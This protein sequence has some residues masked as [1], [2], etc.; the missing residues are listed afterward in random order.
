MCHNQFSA[1]LSKKIFIIELFACL[2]FSLSIHK[3]TAMVKLMLEFD[4]T[5]V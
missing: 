3:Q 5:K 2:F 4:F 1:E